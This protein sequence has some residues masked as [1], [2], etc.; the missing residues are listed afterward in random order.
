MK[1][2]AFK[3]IADAQRANIRHTYTSLSKSSSREERVVAGSTVIVTS[4]PVY[5]TKSNERSVNGGSRR[6]AVSR[7]SR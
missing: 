4:V 7:K 1:A 6:T 5:E 3:V 2:D